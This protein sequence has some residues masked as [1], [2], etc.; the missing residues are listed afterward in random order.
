MGGTSVST[1]LEVSAEGALGRPDIVTHGELV[2]ERFRERARSRKDAFNGGMARPL[3]P[4]MA[5]LINGCKKLISKI[6]FI[7]HAN[8]TRR[9]P[10]RPTR[11]M[12]HELSSPGTQD[13]SGLKRQP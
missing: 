8:V 1:I 7:C 4:P 9:S 5:A 10:G 3:T 12:R 11:T 6:L 2:R 13:T